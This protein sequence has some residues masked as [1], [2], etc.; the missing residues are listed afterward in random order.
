MFLRVWQDAA[1][2][3]DGTLVVRVTAYEFFRTHD[4]DNLG[5]RERLEHLEPVRQ[6]ATTYLIMCRAVDP[7]A[8]PREVAG[9]NERELFL[10]GN[11]LERDG[12]VWIQLRDRVPVRDVVAEGAR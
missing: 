9:F 2:K 10:G 4:P 8:H 3:L 11:L 12:D 5:W 7:D 6:G 1:S